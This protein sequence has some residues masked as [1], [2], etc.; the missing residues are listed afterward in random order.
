MQ[1]QREFFQ[2][3]WASRFR[4]WMIG[5][6]LSGVAFLVCGILILFPFVGLSAL[7]PIFIASVGGFMAGQVVTRA[8]VVY[9]EHKAPQAFTEM[10]LH[11]LKSPETAARIAEA[12]ENA[13]ERAEMLIESNGENDGRERLH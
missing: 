2:I 4:N 6:L 3:M 11:K 9:F 8:I 1:K 12:I 10:L 5:C 7:A 13:H